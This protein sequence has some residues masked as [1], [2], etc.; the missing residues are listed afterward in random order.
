MPS[1][2]ENSHG[3]GVRNAGLLPALLIIA[4]IGALWLPGFFLFDVTSP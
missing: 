2:Y 4:I 3:N 1:N